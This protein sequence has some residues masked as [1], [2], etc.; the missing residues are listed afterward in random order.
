MKLTIVVAVADN[1]A[2]GKNNALLWR[3]PDDLKYFKA[4]TMGK[5][6]IMG[7]KTFQSIGKP[8][9][10]RRNIVVTRQPGLRIEGCDTVD[11]VDAALHAAHPADEA[12]IVGGADIYA[13]V[14]PRVDTIYLTRVHAAPDGD[15]FFPRLD[16]S[17]WQEVFREEH[18]ADARHAHAFTFSTLR[19]LAGA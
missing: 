1:G 3:L 15:V 2:I 11:S 12:M 9:P 5:P 16:P 14:L 6:L 8:L 10:G 19:R 7:R 4:V 17:S 13:Q 18:A